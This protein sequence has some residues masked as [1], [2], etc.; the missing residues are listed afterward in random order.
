M[1]NISLSIVGSILCLSGLFGGRSFA[2][3]QV[4]LSFYTM[5]IGCATAICLFKP[6]RICTCLNVVSDKHHIYFIR[7]IGMIGLFVLLSSW[8]MVANVAF[9]CSSLFSA[10]II[11]FGPLYME[12]YLQASNLLFVHIIGALL[13]FIFVCVAVFG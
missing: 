5:Y 9:R 7:F 2:G 8:F 1:R 6:Y 12:V 11:I 13:G 3:I 4:A 10:C